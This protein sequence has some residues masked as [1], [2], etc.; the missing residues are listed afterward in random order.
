MDINKHP[1]IKQA[2]EVIQAI[3][4]C[5]ASEKLTKAVIMAGD[6]MIAIDKFI[7]R[8]D[9]DKCNCCGMEQDE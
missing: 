1:L 7:D 4:D 9:K 3:E 5:G 6:L 8:Y 2:H